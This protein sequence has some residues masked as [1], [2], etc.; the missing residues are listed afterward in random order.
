MRFF[1][2]AAVLAFTA[3]PALSKTANC[4][5]VADG[6]TWIDGPC[7]FTALKSGEGSFMITGGNGYF[8]YVNINDGEARGDWNGP[9][10]ESRAHW[11]LGMLTRD[12]ACWVNETA[13]VCAK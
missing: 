5:L 13:R 10:K 9:D 8:A 4:E 7:E 12:G 2:A 6:Q 1:V 3:F 11:P